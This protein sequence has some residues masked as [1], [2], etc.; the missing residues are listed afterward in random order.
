MGPAASQAA[1]R[2]AQQRKFGYLGDQETKMAG[3][4]KAT[5]IKTAR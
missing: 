2:I 4:R 1:R 5:P 3:K